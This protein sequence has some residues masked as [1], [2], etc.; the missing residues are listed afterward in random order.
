MKLE[1]IHKK[2]VEEK[3]K[4]IVF[5][6]M[7]GVLVDFGQKVTEINLDPSI[8]S[9]LKKTPDEI[10]AVFQNLNPLNDAIESVY[11]LHDS[12]KYDLFVATTAPW[13]N[14]SSFH[15]KRIWIENHFGNLFAKKMFITHRKDLLIG[16]YLIDDRI[17]NGAG[18]FKG[19]LLHFGWNYELQCWNKF[20]DWDSILNKLLL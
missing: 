11:K 16:K 13:N 7:D 18:D 4:D 1:T 2:T 9:Q 17:A 5:I 19:E 8:S 14:P 12:G 20:K 10:D 6:D 15:D 3:M